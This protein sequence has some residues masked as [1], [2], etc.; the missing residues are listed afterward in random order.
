MARLD[1]SIAQTA[2]L[3]EH[4]APDNFGQGLCMSKGDGFCMHT[5]R[6]INYSVH[7]LMA[8]HGRFT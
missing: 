6:G 7:S 5:E 2:M 8:F 4:G 3:A 1:N